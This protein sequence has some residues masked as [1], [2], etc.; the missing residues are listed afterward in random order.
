M[1]EE[2]AG[3]VVDHGTDEAARAERRRLRDRLEDERARVF[4]RG[5]AAT[6]LGGTFWGLSGTCANY[7]FIHYDADTVWLLSVRQILA[8]AIFMAIA[9]VREREKLVRL[10]TTPA[11]LKNLLLFSY[12][13]L[14]MSQFAYMTTT[15]LTN[16]GTATVLQCLQ[17]LVIMA[18]VCVTTRRRPKLREVVGIGMALAGT[19]LI[20][21]GGDPSNFSIPLAGLVMGLFTALGGANM[22]IIPTKILPVYGSTLVTGTSLFILGLTTNAFVRPWEHIP[23]FGPDGWLCLGVLVVVGTVLAFSLYMQGVRDIGSMRA[24]LLGTIEP[25]SAT[26]ASALVLGIVFSPTDLVGFALIIAMVFLTV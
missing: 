11:H 15:K 7:L 1:A 19:F 25:I 5:V 22:A 18:Y 17:L 6:L 3:K 21:T 2:Q 23:A 26:V 16:A 14:L 24:S 8:G 9:L 12:A 4:I 10:L 20:S 13:G